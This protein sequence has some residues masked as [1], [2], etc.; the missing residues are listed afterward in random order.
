MP[1]YSGGN[2]W[3]GVL[4]LAAPPVPPPLHE[5]A[6]KKT[7]SLAR[8]RAYVEVSGRLIPA[9]TAHRALS[10]LAVALGVH[11]DM[12]R[13]AQSLALARS[14]RRGQSKWKPW[15]MW[16][17][18]A[19]LRYADD[20][21]YFTPARATDIR[22]WT[23]AGCRRRSASLGPKQQPTLS[24]ERKSTAQALPVSNVRT[25]SA[26]RVID[27][28]DVRMPEFMDPG[29][30]LDDL[31]VSLAMVQ[32]LENAGWECSNVLRGRW[33]RVALMHSSFVYEHSGTFPV[34][35]QALKMLGALGSRWCRV[36]ALEEYLERN[37]LASANEQSR[38]WANYVGYMAEGLGNH[39]HIDEVPTT[40]PRRGFPVERSGQGVTRGCRCYMAGHRC[41]VHTP[42][43]GNGRKD[44]P[45]D[46]RRR[47]RGTDSCARL[48]PDFAD[49]QACSDV[50]I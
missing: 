8:K 28:V 18:N 22:S 20:P 49:A 4:A 33:L 29:R 5:M 47:I 44:C 13:V 35:G 40:G 43:A 11:G 45:Q 1:A 38:A 19:V 37:P 34:N 25:Q 6:R 15:P 26:R 9:D 17:Q 23:L 24:R 42:G 39:L 7:S 16:A 36:F 30:V 50:G 14:L 2:R 46:V 27:I 3:V 12:P 31:P 48:V 21:L 41:H 10:M 32:A